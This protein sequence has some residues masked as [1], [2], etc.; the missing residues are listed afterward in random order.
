VLGPAGRRQ[1]PSY[2]APSVSRK[3]LV[4]R[5]DLNPRKSPLLTP[6]TAVFAN[7]LDERE[8]IQL[9]RFE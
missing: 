1:A 5:A 6:D 7:S 3:V 4:L 9:G 2:P 8:E